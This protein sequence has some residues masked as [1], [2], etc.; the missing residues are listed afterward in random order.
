MRLRTLGNDVA[1]R[2]KRV[3]VRVDGNVPVVRGKA[4]DGAHGRIAKAAVGID[5]LRQRGAKV[6]VVTHLGRPDGRRVASLSVTPIAKRLSE[7]LGVTVK[8]SKDIV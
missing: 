8:L 2:G 3:L 7:L 4:V 6:V 5:W 1:V